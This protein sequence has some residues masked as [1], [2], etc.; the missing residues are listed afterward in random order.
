MNVLSSFENPRQITKYQTADKVLEFNDEMVMAPVE[1]AGNLHARYSKIRVVIVDI[2]N[3]K[4]EK[5]VV[6][7]AN[8]DPIKMK[9]IYEKVKEIKH[10]EIEGETV[11]ESK[12]GLGEY[13]DLTPSNA[14]KK[15]GDEAVKKLEELIPILEK[16]ADK[17]P[18]N[19][20]KIEE[21]KAA[22]KAYKAGALKEDVNDF[23]V[24]RIYNEQKI[25]P[26]EKKKNEKGEYPVTVLRIDYN[27]KMRYCWTVY[28]E[29]GWGEI[30]K[31]DNGGIFIKKG[32]YRKEKETKVVVDDESFREMIRQMNDY[33]FQKELLFMSQ[34]QKQLAEYE[35]KK[36][37]EAANK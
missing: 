33:I 28:M 21:I 5:A 13:K 31:R 32:S 17:Y 1:S 20:K 16:N 3:G 27:P 19:N 11:K 22:I 2:S 14:L 4:G 23:S 29:N 7:I 30:E 15:Y 35:E 9:R 18:A 36:R 37:Q 10:F 26:N 6:T 34:L 8:V 25:N 12:I 24:V